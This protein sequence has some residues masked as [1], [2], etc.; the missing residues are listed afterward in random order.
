MN[1]LLEHDLRQALLDRAARIT[2]EATARLRAVDYHPRAHRLP[3]RPV[4][5]AVGLSAAAAA[6]AAALLGSSAAPA[7]A[8]W[9]ASP[10]APL[11]G[12]LAA[13]QQRCG[14]GQGVPVLT[15]IRGPYTSSIYANGST[16]L[17]GN[18]ITISASANAGRSAIPAGQIA[19]NGAGQA[20]ADGHALTMVDGRIG[21]RVRS[22]TITRSNGSSVRATVEHGWYL[23]WWPGTAGALTAIVTT[24]TGTSTQSFPRGPNQLSP[25]CPRGAQC[26]SSYGFSAGPS[27][28]SGPS[29]VRIHGSSRA[30][31]SRSANSSR[32]R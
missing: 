28:G 6:G 14:R 1:D 32:D 18:G 16:C 30:T 26:A 11:P 10:T 21:A 5:G 7:F 23:A 29:T 22:V 27:P 24:S 31:S 3:S 13:A 12:Q 8:G 20:Q 19:L 25:S 2:P 4:L 15:D 17:E 9:S